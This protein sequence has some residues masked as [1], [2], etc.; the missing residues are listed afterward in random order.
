M[1]AHRL[2]PTVQALGRGLINNRSEIFQ[3][4][5]RAYNVQNLNSGYLGQSYQQQNSQYGNDH[6]PWGQRI[7][8]NSRG[9]FM[10]VVS[11]SLHTGNALSF[12][13]FQDFENEHAHAIL[14]SLPAYSA[15]T[16]GEDTPDTAYYHYAK[17]PSS[18]DWSIC[19]PNEVVEGFI[20]ISQMCHHQPM[21][22][23]DAQHSN[24]CDVLSK[25]LS[26][27]SDQQLMSVLSSLAIWPPTD[28]ITSPNFVGLWNALDQECTQRMKKWGM[29]QMFLV[30]DHWYALRL[31]RISMYTVQMTK[32]LGRK[33]SSM[34]PSQ[35]VQYLFYA[36][37]SRKLI[38]LIVMNDLEKR[39]TE[40]LQHVSIEELGVIAMGFFKTQTFLK[41]E[42][43]IEYIIKKTKQNLEFVS[44][45]SLCAILKILRKSVPGTQWKSL[46]GLLDSLLPHIPRLN[47]M[48]LLQVALLGNNLLVFHQGA[49]NAIALRFYKELKFLRLKDL[50]RMTFALMLYSYVPPSCPDFFVKIAEELRQP[51]RISEIN[52]YPK[53]FV[54][55]IVYLVTM[56]LYP[57][58]LISA[59][60][61]PSML[62]LLKKNINYADMAREVNEL[63]WAVEIEGPPGYPGY[64]LDP[65]TR[66]MLTKKYLAKIPSKSAR[67][68]THQEKLILGV[69]EKLGS[70]LGGLDFVTI[71]NI[72]PHVQTPDLVFCTSSEGEPIE[73]PCEF[74]D[75]DPS[76]LKYP[77]NMGRDVRW[78]AVI[79]GGRNSFIRNTS[80]LQGNV[81]MKKRQLSLLGYNVS[82][83]PHME[84][85]RRGVRAKLECIKRALSETSTLCLEGRVES[86]LIS[87]K[88]QTAVKEEMR[89]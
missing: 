67:D 31:S 41:N 3:Q 89:G 60:L 76:S 46:E 47:H 8:H 22:L 80:F 84:Y 81:Q 69:Q 73:L 5:V 30:A 88:G 17:H 35:L 56:G 40:V 72:L 64:R 68:L 79:I 21:N 34:E 33:V 18:V 28:T 1:C 36:N 74:L 29:S 49:V 61:Q 62:A 78:N 20:A 82:V 44:D 12:K 85:N 87:I 13:D 39:L 7:A 63:D 38:P 37:L 57:P 24:L 15:T 45:A 42:Q 53:C 4:G 11:Q 54:S 83:I 16:V 9:A 27:I 48:C 6:F 26:Y 59:A 51:E 50:E 52:L 43:L 32:H 55:C 65:A 58:D 19:S 86:A 66:I 70:L 2:W 77:L 14:R 75:M 23:E 25:N 10:R 71:T